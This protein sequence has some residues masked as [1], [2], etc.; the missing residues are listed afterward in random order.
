MICTTKTQ[1]QRIVESGVYSC[2]PF[3]ADTYAESEPC[4]EVPY[5]DC[6]TPKACPREFFWKNSICKPYPPAER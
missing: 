5:Y 1:T 6:A 4:Q 3:S 2:S